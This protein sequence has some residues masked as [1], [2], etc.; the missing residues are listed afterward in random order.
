MAIDLCSSR[1]FLTLPTSF[2]Q[3]VFKCPQVRIPLLAECAVLEADPIQAQPWRQS[4]DEEMV[5]VP[6][7]GLAMFPAH[8]RYGI[9]EQEFGRRLM[10]VLNRDTTPTF[11]AAIQGFPRNDFEK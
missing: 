11:S 10:L 7:T 2:V 9:T 8:V 3:S 1:E 4:R 6:E 5:F